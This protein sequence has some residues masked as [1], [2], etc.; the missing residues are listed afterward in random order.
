[1]V[2]E[3]VLRLGGVMRVPTGAGND[4]EGVSAEQSSGQPWREQT[5]TTGRGNRAG[6]R[7]G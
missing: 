1:V 6:E 3:R 7:R 4:G 2:V 5:G